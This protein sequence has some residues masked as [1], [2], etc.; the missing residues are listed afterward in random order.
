MDI[1]RIVNNMREFYYW[2]CS[3]T[4]L[5]SW[6]L[7]IVAIAII[8][9]LERLLNYLR[10]LKIQT[11]MTRSSNRSHFI[12]THL[13]EKKKRHKA[14]QTQ[15]GDLT[16]NYP[17][18]EQ[19]H[20][21]WGQTTKD[22]RKLREKIRHLERDLTKRERLE[23][24]LKEEIASLKITNEKL[25]LEINKKALTED[26]LQQQINELTDTTFV[27]NQDEQSIIE[28]RSHA[29][30]I[31][32]QRDKQTVSSSNEDFEPEDSTEKEQNSPLDIKELKAIADLVKQLQLRSQQR[33]R[34]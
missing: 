8:F 11:L 25:Q 26:T 14:Q 33:H 2:I 4:G 12:G 1:D 21:P 30:S 17:E 34:E 18:D 6:Q 15:E 29:E 31:D 10:K 27:Q 9:L 3:K 7:L 19:E 28:N 13:S 5:K 23:K 16:E 20:Q 32:E 24:Q 22:W